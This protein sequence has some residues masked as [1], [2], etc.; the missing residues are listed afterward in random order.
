MKEI[1]EIRTGK[2]EVKVF[3]FVDDLILYIKTSKDF[4]R[5]LLQMINKFSKVARHKVNTHKYQ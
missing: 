4:T 2:E 5:N 1:R 3:L